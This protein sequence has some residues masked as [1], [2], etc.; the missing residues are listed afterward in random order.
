MYIFSD[1][2]RKNN[3]SELETLFS[4]PITIM[5][6]GYLHEI[7]APY[8]LKYMSIKTFWNLV[9]VGMELPTSWPKRFVEGFQG[10][11]ERI[12]VGIDVRL[13][14]H[15]QK[16][17]RG[18][19]I[20]VFIEGEPEELEFDYLV[21]ACPLTPNN[22]HQFLELTEQETEIFEKVVVNPFVVTTN[23]KAG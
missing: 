10:F 4:M 12:S 1:W 6:Y 9:S 8:A 21:L 5:G 23:S 3:L 2:L 11:W 14:V 18:N 17:E 13:N 7:A 20:R 22:L 15:I 19:V 16:I